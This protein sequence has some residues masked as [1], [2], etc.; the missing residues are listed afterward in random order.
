MGLSNSDGQPAPASSKKTRGP[1]TKVRDAKRRIYV[2]T[3]NVVYVQESR[4]ATAQ[5]GRLD[6]DAHT[7]VLYGNV[8][9]ADGEQVL[10]A[11]TVR[12]D[13]LT[14]KVISSANP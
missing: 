5:N 3:G 13:T 14:K 6:E 12:Y 4:R 7:L 9:L 8:R 11:Q 2:A 1:R 10:T